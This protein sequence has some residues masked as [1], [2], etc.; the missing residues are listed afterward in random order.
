LGYYAIQ[1]LDSG[2]ATIGTMDTGSTP[3]KDFF[4]ASIKLVT[5]KNAASPLAVTGE[6]Q[7]SCNTPSTTEKTTLDQS[8]LVVTLLGNDF[9]T[10][11][12]T[13]TTASEATT[14]IVPMNSNLNSIHS[15]RFQLKVQD[16]VGFAYKLFISMNVS[17]A[18]GSTVVVETLVGC[19]TGGAT[20]KINAGSIVAAFGVS[21]TLFSANLF[22]RIVRA[23]ST[24][25][26]A[27]FSTTL[28]VAGE[29]G[30]PSPLHVVFGTTAGALLKD[31]NCYGC[32]QGKLLMSRTGSRQKRGTHCAPLSHKL[33]VA[34]RAPMAL[35]ARTHPH[36]ATR[37]GQTRWVAP[38]LSTW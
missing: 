5:G 19:S 4:S 10:N 29:N 24:N 35:H 1:M 34:H 22:P 21:K 8:N 11:A 2:G 15:G 17:T 9:T 16:Q 7:D 36:L 25:G 27:N 3:D 26:F 6:N 31:A 23:D 28:N 33:C 18:V 20:F 38:R 13:D 14:D 32:V 12:G 30:L 37:N